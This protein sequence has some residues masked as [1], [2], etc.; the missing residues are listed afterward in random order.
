MYW[1]L[2][3]QI[4]IDGNVKNY[5]DKEKQHPHAAGWSP[6]DGGD[7]SIQ[8]IGDLRGHALVGTCLAETT[9]PRKSWQQIFA[10][11]LGSV[12][13]SD[14]W[15]QQEGVRLTKS[16]LDQA[17]DI[18]TKS[19]PNARQSIACLSAHFCRAHGRGAH[20]TR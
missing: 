3:S 4:N 10:S 12:N 8:A 2:D 20:F 19:L 14:F 1:L 13:A 9:A 15:Y 7:P 17:A 11:N 5:G 16:D 18:A 6:K